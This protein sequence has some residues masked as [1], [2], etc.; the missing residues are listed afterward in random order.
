MNWKAIKR[1]YECVLVRNDK[2]EYLGENKYKL[3][4]YHSSGEKRWE[5]EYRNELAHGKD[6][7]WQKNGVEFRRYEFRD[8]KPIKRKETTMSDVRVRYSRLEKRVPKNTLATI[9]DGDTV[10]FGIARC[11]RKMDTF[12]R[13]VGTHI[14]MARAGL[15]QEGPCN[16]LHTTDGDDL[17]VH[18]SRMRGRTTVE[19]VKELIKYFNNIDAVCLDRR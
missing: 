13:D 6:I 12:K 4:E 17:E 3:T 16:D 1:I 7:W 10:Y 19:N 9:R 15:A 14:A 11:N 2:I 18:V 5:R 8:G